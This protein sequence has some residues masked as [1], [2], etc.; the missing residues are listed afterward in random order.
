MH[1]HDPTL[2]MML[3]AKKLKVFLMDPL[4]ICPARIVSPIA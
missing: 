2:K 4:T 1:I 3:G